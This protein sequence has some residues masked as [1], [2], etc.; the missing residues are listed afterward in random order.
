MNDGMKSL[1]ELREELKLSSPAIVHALRELVTSHFIRQD[2][3]RNYLVTPIGRSAARKVIDFQDA[4][5]VL[6]KNEAFWSEHDISGI[7]DR[8]FDTI[9][10]LRDA[11]LIAGTPPDIFK[12]LRH[13]VDLF[14]DSK[15]VKMVSPFYIQD[16]GQLALQQF[17][18]QQH[19]ELVLTH[20]V[21]RHLIDEIGRERL[22]KACSG[23]LALYEIRENPKLVLVVTDTF[24]ALALHRLDG[25]FD[26]SYALTS[27]NKDAIAWG[28]ELFEYHIASSYSVVL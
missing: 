2:L 13:F 4:M 3:E 15:V 16:I 6:M 1:R 21:S 26:Y 8:L 11:G 18:R 23:H 28:Q 14:R 20:E 25:T 24:M 10:S 19:V 12:A 27:Q 17:A 5:A 9:G 22:S 7:P